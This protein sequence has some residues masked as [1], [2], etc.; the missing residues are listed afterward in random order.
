MSIW[1]FAEMPRG[2]SG[3]I[4]P[5]CGPRAIPPGADARDL[6]AFAERHGV[7][8]QVG[9]GGPDR[10]AN[11]VYEQLREHIWNDPTMELTRKRQLLG[12]LNGIANR[13]TDGAE[14]DMTD[15][16][17]CGLQADAQPRRLFPKA[18]HAL[19]SFLA[20]LQPR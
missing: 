1:G 3:G 16:D 20:S 19:T 4:A 14:S 2:S 6:H 8:L 9:P 7:P 5:P 11:R 12:E 18:G 15:I 10:D 13:L 17:R